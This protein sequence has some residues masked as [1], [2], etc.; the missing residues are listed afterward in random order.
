LICFILGLFSTATLIAQETIVQG[1]VTD[2]TSGDPIPFVNVV[3]KGTS[4]G[5]TTD[6]DGNFLIKTTQRFDSVTAT[7]IGYKART[8]AIKPGTN[9]PSTSSW[10]RTSLT[11]RKS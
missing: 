3:F 2:A 4:I 9:K 10:Q 7:Y 5:A 6:F 1:K 11:S 8:K